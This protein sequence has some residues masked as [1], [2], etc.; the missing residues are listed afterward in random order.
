MANRKI[1]CEKCGRQSLMTALNTF[2]DAV[3]TM[4][5]KVMVPSRLRDMELR[6]EMPNSSSIHRLNTTLEENNNNPSPVPFSPRCGEDLYS[7]YNMINAVKSELITGTK[8][9]TPSD[10]SLEMEFLSDDSSDDS[11]STDPAHKT[12]RAF[13]YHLQ[14]LFSVLHQLTDTAKYLG[15]AYEQQ[16]DSGRKPQKFSF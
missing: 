15:D 4:D 2:V 11:L 16:V 10:S 6:G 3:N 8:A 1:P 12:A 7:Y 13:Q 9:K 5:D 14:G